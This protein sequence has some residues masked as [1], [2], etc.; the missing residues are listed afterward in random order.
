MATFN[1]LKSGSW[2][3]QVRRKGRYA[4]KTFRQKSDGEAWALE[5]E[6]TLLSGQSLKAPKIDRTTTFARLIQLHIKDM[7]KVSRRSKA[8]CLD[9][10][11]LTLGPVALVDLDRERLIEFGKA[12]A[13]EGAGP[14]TLSMDIGYIRTVLVHAAAVHGLSV[15]IEQVKLARVALNRLDLIGKGLERDR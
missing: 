1:K 5:S 9:K 7:G 4:S 10:L 2:R 13:Q 15:P 14:M 6:R 12:R 11:E 8:S 3:V